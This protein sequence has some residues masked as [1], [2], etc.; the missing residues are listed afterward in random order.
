[1]EL[2]TVTDYVFIIAGAAVLF[3][4]LV[5]YFAGLKHNSLFEGLDNKEY[6]L[7]DIYGL[8]Y[9]VLMLFRHNFK[10]KG[11]RKIRQH[12][13]ILYD[14]KYN[15]YYIRVVR[16]Q[17]VTIGMTILVIAFALYGLGS[18][19]LLTVV[20]IVM[21]GTIFYYYGTVPERKIQERSD[22]LVHDFSEVVSKLAL[23]TNAGSILKEAWEEVAYGSEGIIYDEMK[24]AVVDMNNG[25]SEV[26]AIHEFGNRCV[27]P[28][29]K[30]FAST[31]AMGVTRGNSELVYMLQEQSKEVW[32]LKKQLVKR[33][34]EKAGSKLLLPLCLM[35]IGI[36]I[37][38]MVPIFS[39]MGV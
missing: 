19:A 39:N 37:M 12:L 4:W 14:K 7:K 8:G 34:A 13:E 23:L 22:E 36:L 26:D 24:K 28:E 21:A 6:P 18:S 17:Q 11:D 35:F 16:S 30:K 31:I 25:V 33:D 38:I 5:F 32:Q 10:S 15:D 1:M 27:I 29:V 9:A 20:G 2:L 3:I